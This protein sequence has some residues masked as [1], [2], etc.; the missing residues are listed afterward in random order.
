MSYAG[1]I[2]ITIYRILSGK[3]LIINGDGL[4]TR[5]YTLVK[6]ISENLSKFYE[7]TETRGKVINLAN[8]KEIT[9][10]ELI[11]MIIELM[12]YSGDIIYTEP[13]LGARAVN[14]IFRIPVA[15]VIL[16]I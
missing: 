15:R 7:I 12:G 10:K 2:P 11:L 16:N 9:I 8:S 13:R 6:D 4:Q 1:V 14:K 3:S 5:D